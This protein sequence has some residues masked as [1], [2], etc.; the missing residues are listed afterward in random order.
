MINK[1][2]PAG[3]RSLVYGHAELHDCLAIAD[4]ETATAEAREIVAIA[5][6]RT[7]GEARGIAPRHVWNPVPEIEDDPDEHDDA[8]SFDINQVGR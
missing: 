1:P 2:S 5:S 6:A 3:T 4:G 8:A 7:W